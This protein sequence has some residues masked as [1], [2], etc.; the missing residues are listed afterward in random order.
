[1]LSVFL[2][3]IAIAIIDDVRAILKD[4]LKDAKGG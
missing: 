3:S 1:M 4:I 2:L